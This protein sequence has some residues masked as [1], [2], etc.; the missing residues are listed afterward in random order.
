MAENKNLLPIRAFPALSEIRDPI[1]SELNRRKTS[2]GQNNLPSTV[3]VR[4]VSNARPKTTNT[5][6]RRKNERKDAYILM[7]AGALDNGRIRGGFESIYYSRTGAKENQN[8][9]RPTPGITDIS[10]TMIGDLGSIRKA[11][12]TWIAPS[13]YDLEELSPYFLVPG[14]TAILEWGYGI[15]EE[16]ITAIGLGSSDNEIG[17]KM[18]DFFN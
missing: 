17:A 14:S 5:K 12:I 6:R 1:Q 9:Y 7:G 16:Q 10:I 2:F 15:F 3:W 8:F 18:V 11:V 4:L 13:V